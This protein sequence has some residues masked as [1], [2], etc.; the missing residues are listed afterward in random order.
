MYSPTS[1]SKHLVLVH[2]LTVVVAT[3]LLLIRTVLSQN[4][5]NDYL[6]HKCL[7][8]HGTFK[9]GSKYDK[10][11]NDIILSIPLD[12]LRRGVQYA[13][14]DMGDDGG[15][16]NVLIYCRGDSHGKPC[17][18]CYYTA[19][20][21]LRRRCPNYKGGVIWY[22]Q[23][24]LEFSAVDTKGKLNLESFCMSNPKKLNGDISSFHSKW[25]SLQ[26]KLTT[27]A[28]LD[29]DSSLYATGE[30]MFDTK[31]I[32]G[33]VQCMKDLPSSTAC[34]VCIER[35]SKKFENCWRDKQGGRFVGRSCSF[36]FEFY[37]FFNAKSPKN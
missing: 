30:T 36:R 10:E 14:T 31:K 1:I 23:C 26:K 33:M 11:R 16:M 18:S 25:S 13:G 22:D 3:Q 5:T 28:L 9:P 21:G 12:D 7:A 20:A 29:K 37:P 2:F 4:V 8:N 24:F 15:Y 19:V 6:N 32:Y 34:K 27:T 17:R 35:L